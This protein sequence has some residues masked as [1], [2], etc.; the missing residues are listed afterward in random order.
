MNSYAERTRPALNR[1]DIGITLRS[2]PPVLKVDA[3]PL[4]QDRAAQMVLPLLYVATARAAGADEEPTA[5]KEENEHDDD[6]EGVRIH[7]S[8]ASRQNTG[9]QS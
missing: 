6:E 9:P 3:D 4:G 5:A 8:H 2:L 7:M 1:V